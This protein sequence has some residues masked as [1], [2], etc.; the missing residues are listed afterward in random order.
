MTNAVI[1][2][3]VPRKSTARLSGCAAM[4]IIVK[5]ANQPALTILTAGKSYIQ[6]VQGMIGAI[7]SSFEERWEVR[8]GIVHSML[9]WIA[10]ASF[11]SSRF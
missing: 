3:V 7:R 6:S 11:T 2:T 10:D 5:S 4:D 8:V 9:P 1:S